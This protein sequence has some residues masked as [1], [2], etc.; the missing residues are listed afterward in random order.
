MTHVIAS[1]CLIKFSIV[2]Q[3]A[4][5]G[6]NTASGNPG[7]FTSQRLVLSMSAGKPGPRLDARP[8]DWEV[9]PF[10]AQDRQATDAY[11]LAACD[12]PQ[13]ARHHLLPAAYLP[14]YAFLTVGSFAKSEHFASMTILPVSRTY[15][16]W[17]VFSAW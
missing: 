3:I 1:A 16:L 6:S 9:P 12:E 17:A 2:R 13:A 15:P 10:P 8:P 5:G 11:F 4:A 14:R 7:L